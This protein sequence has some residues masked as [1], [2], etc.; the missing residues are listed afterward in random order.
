MKD[1]PTITKK[2]ISIGS[3]VFEFGKDLLQ[4]KEVKE[5]KIIDEIKSKVDLELMN[6]C[7]KLEESTAK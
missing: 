4:S 2:L 7:K 6:S 5:Q 3:S 1:E